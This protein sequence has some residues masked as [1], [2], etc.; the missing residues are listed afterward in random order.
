MVKTP[1][2]VRNEYVRL[3]G[4]DLGRLF[5]ELTTEEDWL[6]DKWAVFQELFEHGQERIDLLNRAASNFFWS[7]HKLLFEDAMLHLSRLTDPPESNGKKTNLTVLSLPTSISDPKLKDSVEKA[8]KGLIKSC[9]FA[10]D[11]RNRR[12]AHADLSTARNE[13]PHSLPAVKSEDIA[14]ALQCLRTVL[15]L[16]EKYYRIP[17]ALTLRDPWGACAL[18]HCLQIADR[19]KDERGLT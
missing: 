12:L 1:E 16:I 11:M 18:V 8:I 6:R 13:H 3:M 7:L 5:H 14:R 19:A 4:A 2:E 9:E 15:L 17:P 10:R